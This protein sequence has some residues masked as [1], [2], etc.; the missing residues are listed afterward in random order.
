MQVVISN[1]IKLLSTGAFHTCN[2]IEDMSDYKWNQLLYIAKTNKVEDFIISGIFYSENSL[3]S[4][5]PTKVIES[6]KKND[7]TTKNISQDN[8]YRHSSKTI[9]KFSNS[10]LNKKLN[11]IVYD[12]VHSIDTS[13]DSITF[14]NR[15]IDNIKNLLSANSYIRDLIEYGIY[16]R[17]Y[18]NKI[19]FVKIGNWINLLKMGKI[20]NLVGIYLIKFFD[21]DASEIPF[22]DDSQGQINVKKVKLPLNL[23]V[24][25]TEDKQNETQK[26][27][28]SLICN[29]PKPN[30]GMFKYFTFFPLE[31]TSV[32][33][34]N[35]FKS[36]SNIE[37]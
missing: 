6:I 35:I 11:R 4:I 10:Y 18:G 21:F 3:N 14:L 25:L 30:I 8:Q 9:K 32:F 19:D 26:E 17:E 22:Y 36:L 37:E 1:F 2:E 33:F 28:N 29:V 5:I 27:I 31:V 23:H 7:N 20:M 24:M 15:S 16:L 34:S 12:E 13:I